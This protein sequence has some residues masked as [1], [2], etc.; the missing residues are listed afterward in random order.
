MIC[1]AQFSDYK[2]GRLSAEIE[3]QG[4]FTNNEFKRHVTYGYTVGGVRFVPKLSYNL[5]DKIKF[6]FGFSALR[7]W[8]TN[9]YPLNSYV[10]IPVYEKDNKQ[11]LLHTLPY[12]RF[13]WKINPQTLFILGNTDKNEGHLL[14]VALWNPELKFT[15]D[16]EEGL[17]IKHFSKYWSNDLWLNWQKFNYINDVDRESFL[18]G[19]S[20]KLNTDYEKKHVLFFNYAFMWQHHGGELDTLKSLPLD[21]WVNGSFGLGYT[22]RLKNKIKELSFSLDWVYC[23]SLRNDT[24]YFKQGSGILANIS[25]L[26]NNYKVGMGYYYSK[27]MTSFYG[28]AFFSNIAQ[29]NP[30]E[31]YPK[32][33]LIYAQFSYT[34]YKAGDANISLFTNLYYKLDT[35]TNLGTENRSLSFSFGIGMDFTTKHTVK[36]F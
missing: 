14:N 4:Y 26:G 27:N 17:Q 32:N 31:Y 16:Y 34:P 15:M 35:K 20:G 21:H 6:Y 30:E 19:T 22:L 18:L 28:S 24:W 2:K 8:G 3:L 5:T 11:K 23:K 10:L 9:D 7:L 12:L 36:D 1:F 25:A 29:R 33:H 13:E